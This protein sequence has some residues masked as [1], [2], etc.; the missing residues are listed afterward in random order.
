M[1]DTSIEL[2]T[3]PAQALDRAGTF[4]ATPLDLRY[5]GYVTDDLI[6]HLLTGEFGSS[7]A[8][9]VNSSQRRQLV[10]QRQRLALA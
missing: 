9:P 2:I 6:D 1:S 10:W 5:L 7:L 8:R 4:R 3:I